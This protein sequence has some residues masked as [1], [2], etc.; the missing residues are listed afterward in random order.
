MI[1]EEELNLK[2]PV[3]LS[4]SVRGIEC[5]TGWHNLLDQALSELDSI[6]PENKIILFVAKEKFG[7]LDIQLDC[8]LDSPELWSDTITPLTSKYSS[9]SRNVCET[10]GD[11]GQHRTTGYWLYTS[12]D[13]HVR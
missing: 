12:C 2:Y 9:A 8:K 5:G 6:D 10:C 7:V 1:T 11:P 4:N 13:K 3:R